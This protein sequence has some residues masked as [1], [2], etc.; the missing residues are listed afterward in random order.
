MDGRKQINRGFL[1]VYDTAKM[2]YRVTTMVVKLMMPL[3]SS[4]DVLLSV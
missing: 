4:S 2:E 3:S 1:L